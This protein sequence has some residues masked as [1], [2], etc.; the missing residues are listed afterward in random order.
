MFDALDKYDL[1]E[2]GE[3]YARGSALSKE[4]L[5][6]KPARI[7]FRPIIPLSRMKALWAP[8]F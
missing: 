4:D 6:R 8:T 7:T 3:V 5:A 2:S 1:G